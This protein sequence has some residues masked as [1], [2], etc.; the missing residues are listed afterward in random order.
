MAPLANNPT[1][2]QGTPCFVQLTGT[3]LTNCASG[4]LDSDPDAYNASTANDT[5]GLNGQGY[6]AVANSDVFAG[7]G[8]PVAQYALQLSLGAKT[9]GGTAYAATCQLTTVLKDAGNNTYS[10]TSGEII[11]KS[12][13]DPANKAG[14]APSWYNPSNFSSTAL[15]AQSYDPNVASVSSTGL[16][17]ARNKGQCVIEVMYPTHDVDADLSGIAAVDNVTLTEPDYI[18][19]Q[20]VCTVVA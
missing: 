20:I 1:D 17:T 11:Y 8:F 18:Y 16:I 12:Y 3:N 15:P 9:I 5:T 4:G 2:G 10:G 13:G 7:P 19:A 6:G 14:S